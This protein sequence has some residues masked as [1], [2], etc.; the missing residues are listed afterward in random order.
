MS[1]SVPSVLKPQAQ[2]PRQLKREQPRTT[3]TYNSHSYSKDKR[4]DKDK[5]KERYG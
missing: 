2:V 1:P 4:K 3:A 5:R